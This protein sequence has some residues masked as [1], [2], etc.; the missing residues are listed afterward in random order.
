MQPVCIHKLAMGYSDTGLFT[1]ANLVWGPFCYEL[2]K[3]GCLDGRVMRILAPYRLGIS[4]LSRVDSLES[5][6]NLIHPD[7]SERYLDHLACLEEADHLITVYRARVE[8]A[9][10]AWVVDHLIG[11]T[12]RPDGKLSGTMLLAHSLSSLSSLVGPY[13]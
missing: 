12:N 8:R 5:W 6:V 3:Y 2:Q 7:D 10:Y 4:F 11:E 13:L 1:G 9:N